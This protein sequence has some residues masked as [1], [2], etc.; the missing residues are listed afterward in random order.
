MALAKHFDKSLLAGSAVLQGFDP[1]AFA[2]VLEKHVVALSWDA[3]SASSPAGRVALE[4]S[5]ELLARLYPTLLLEARGEGA[6]TF[7]AEL[8]ERA[9]EI[10]GLVSFAE[11][12]TAT[13]RISLGSAE[14][15]AFSE[16]PTFHI[17]FGGWVARLSSTRPVAGGQGSNPF[18]A[19]VAA[20]LGAANVFR[21]VFWAQLPAGEPDG[22]VEFSV[23]TL[24]PLEEEPS[25]P[26][27]METDLGEVFLV[28]AGAVGSA[29]VW[30]LARA[31]GLSGQLHVID[32]EKLDL[33]NVQRY[34]GTAER[35]VDSVKV[36]LAA[37]TLA[38]SAL[39]V[40]THP[41][42]W[43]EFLHARGDWH[44]D[45]VA[46]AVDSARDRVH[47][48]GALPRW[49]AN[50]W[51][52]P[53]NV[54]ISRHL[55]DGEEACLACL[56][57]PE[58]MQRSEDEIIASALGMS[59]RP[60]L[61]RI[62]ALLHRAVPLDEE[63]VRDAATCMGV[64]PDLLLGFVGQ[65]LRKFYSGAV[66]SGMVLRMGG[67]AEAPRAEIP[68][69]FQSAMAG[70]LLAAELVAEVGTLRATPLPTTTV[71]DL[72]RPLG[73]VLSAPTRKAGTGAC[74]CEDPDYLAV[75]R[76]KYFGALAASEGGAS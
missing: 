69:A 60:A 37:A 10:N 68:L 55:L 64:D 15:S 13:V 5:V 46:V 63:F 47:V 39:E 48:Q 9:R 3:E 54:G 57:M 56:Y 2:D 41:C 66:C 62:R 22:E 58:S 25:N 50:A 23:L 29:A 32:P 75:Y 30:T 73:T 14:V 43:G 33:T 45:R 6:D 8:A 65:T 35:D 18:G 49:I 70:V 1:A 40:H 36:E 21:H 24:D 7:E 20:C 38:G 74:I 52:Q 12:G 11:P 16:A 53:G 31:P 27:L 44:L 71:M 28:G 34:T 76:A 19:A 72:L 4:M 61:L 42:S 59:G 26:A 17:G 51:T 67:H